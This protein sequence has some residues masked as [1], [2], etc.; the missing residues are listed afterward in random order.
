M[1]G[2]SVLMGSE[3]FEYGFGVAGRLIARLQDFGSI[4]GCGRRTEE[5]RGFVRAF[6]DERDRVAYLNAC[7]EVLDVAVAEANAAVGS[8]LADGVWPVGAVNA[9]ALDVKANPAGAE[10]VIRAGADNYAGMVV[11]GI[12][13]AAHDVEFTGGA[14]AVCGADGD[15]VDAEDA[16]AFGESQFAIRK[17]DDDVAGWR[18]RFVGVCGG[19]LS[20][21][22]SGT[23][24]EGGEDSEVEAARGVCFG[25]VG[26]A[27]P[28]H[29]SSLL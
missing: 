1:G 29:V 20:H 13:Q 22:G 15:V 23:A 18:G 28:V 24:E 19:D 5:T 9:E 25:V 7:E 27:W 10:R 3:I 6:G 4:G 12:F 16:V 2:N 26:V 8:V 14:G 17:A 21:S 11:G